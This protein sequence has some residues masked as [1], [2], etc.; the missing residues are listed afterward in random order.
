[1]LVCILIISGLGAVVSAD[2]EE[3]YKQETKTLSLKNFALLDNNEFVTIEI[4]DANSLFIKNNYFIIPSHIETFSFPINTKI[5]NIEVVPEIISSHKLEK[6]LI[7]AREPILLNKITTSIEN[8]Q[9]L[10]PYIIDFWYNY[11]IGVGLYENERRVIVKVQLFPVQYHPDNDNFD[12][13]ERF[14]IDIKYTIPQPRMSQ[15]SNDNYELLILSIDEFTNELNNLIQHKKD[16]EISSKLVTISEITSGMYFPPDGRDIQEQIKYFIKNAIEQWNTRYVLLVGG[17]DEFPV[18]KTHV[19]V[20]YNDGDAE[21]FVS[22]LYYADI[23]DGTSSFCSWD[24]NSN[25]VFGEFDWTST[26]LYDDVDLYPDV[27]L[28]R[29]ACVNINEVSTCVNKI[30]DYETA[31]SYIQNWF[32]QIILCGGDTAPGDDEGVDEGEY[33]CDII[34]N[35]MTGFTPTKLYASN[36]GLSNVMKMKQEMNKGSGWLVLAGHA[37]PT[38]WSTHP[39]DNENVWVPPRGFS[40]DDALFLLNK[41]KLP[42]LLTDA[43][44][45]FKFNVRDDC[46]GWNFMVNPDGGAIGGFGATGLSW[47]SDGYSV[48][49]YLTSKLMIDT[50]KAYRNTGAITLG[51]MWSMGIS[52]YIYTGMDGGDH[53]SI[54]EWQLLGDPSLALAEESQEPLKPS[55]PNGPNTGKA[56][57]EKIYTVSTIDPDG[58]D[59]Y[60]MFDWDDNSNIIWI[61]PYPSGVTCEASHTWT[62]Q[63]SYEIRVK[64]MDIHGK[65]SEWSEPLTVSMPKKKQKTL[66][67]LAELFETMIERLPMIENLLNIM[68]EIF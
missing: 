28:G 47:G 58:D 43:C 20:D 13:A 59:I 52:E 32:S 14:K 29:L 21:E 68:N 19:F 17:S 34:E 53:K 63:G 22:D 9:Q 39:H 18:R 24:S 49:E 5:H 35:V 38:S 66:P 30:I 41:E 8:K 62:T 4:K 2:N 7:I 56:G 6:K 36:G 55:C 3:K 33:I 23:Y 42:I 40:N 16:R 15:H 10:N 46:L 54:E 31:P 12:F 67:G 60:Y 26:S 37:N 64:A 27:Y 57:E 25:N 50:I 1:L 44:S 51:E 48:I 45:P 65:Q 61:G 11:D